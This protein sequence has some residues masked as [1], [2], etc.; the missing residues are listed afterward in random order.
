MKL[1]LFSRVEELAMM[2]KVRTDTSA[3]NVRARVAQFRRDGEQRFGSARALRGVLRTPEERAATDD[4]W[5]RAY[6]EGR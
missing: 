1:R 2:S 4:A 5:Q 6:D 3:R